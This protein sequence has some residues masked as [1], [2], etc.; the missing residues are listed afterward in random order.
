[1]E[2]TRIVS[3]RLS[4]PQSLAERVL[5]MPSPAGEGASSSPSGA[6]RAATPVRRDRPAERPGE[7]GDRSLGTRGSGTER[8]FLALCIAS[9]GAGEQALGELDIDD[10]FTSEPMRRAARHLRGHLSDPQAG[11]PE[12]DVELASLIARLV[13][14]AGAESARAVMLEVQ[15]LQLELARMDRHIQLTRAR[16][17]GEVTEL[18]HR[19]TEIKRDFERAYARVLEETAPSET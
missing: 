9:P 6:A 17:E 8:A 18:A 16:Q 3:E 7:A 1:M 4:L 10:S 19:R 11:L 2:L 14:E 15:R 5:A 12:D 13:V